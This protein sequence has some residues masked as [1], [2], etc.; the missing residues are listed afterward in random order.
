VRLAK[1]TLTSAQIHPAFRCLRGHVL[2]GHDFNIGGNCIR[3]ICQ[4]CHREL[5][6]IAVSVIDDEGERNW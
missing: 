1:R 3:L 5:I 2:T 6:T 4:S